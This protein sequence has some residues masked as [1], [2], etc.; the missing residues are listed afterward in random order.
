MISTY[1]LK[2]KHRKCLTDVLLFGKLKLKKKWNQFSRKRIKPS[3]IASSQFL[4]NARRYVIPN[5]VEMY[6]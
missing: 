6:P 4:G 5:I 3:R 1:D 2:H